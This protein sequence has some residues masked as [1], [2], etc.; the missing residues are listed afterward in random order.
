MCQVIRTYA[1][2][3][4]QYQPQHVII[5]FSPF[6]HPVR[7]PALGVAVLPHHRY[8]IKTGKPCLQGFYVNIVVIENQ[9]EDG[10]SS[11]HAVRGWYGEHSVLTHACFGFYLFFIPSL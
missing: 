10:P 6:L 4:P 11:K 9:H 2:Y 1:C 3:I 5:L 7:K 8:Y